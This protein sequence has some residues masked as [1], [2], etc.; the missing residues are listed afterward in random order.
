MKQQLFKDYDIVQVILISL[1]ILIALLS[2]FIHSQS[3]FLG[4][5]FISLIGLYWLYTGFKKIRASK[6]QQQTLRW[7]TQPSILFGI[8]AFFFAFNLL[9]K[10]VSPATYVM[11]PYLEDILSSIALLFFL[12]ATWFY[13][14]DWWQQRK[15]ARM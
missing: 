9:L 2:F 3:T 14:R 7:Y 8:G 6:T 12:A 11:Y 15:A 13:A 5:A 10:T 4:I 1:W